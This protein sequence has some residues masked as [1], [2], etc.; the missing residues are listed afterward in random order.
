LVPVPIA[1]PVSRPSRA[2]CLYEARARLAAALFDQ[3]HHLLEQWYQLVLVHDAWLKDRACAWEALEEAVH[4]CQERDQQLLALE[5]GLLAGQDELR[6]RQTALAQV[7]CA[8]EGWHAR[9]TVRESAW[10]TDRSALIAE[11]DER[12][13]S[14]AAQAARIDELGRHRLERRAQEIEALRQARV[15]C[16]EMRRDYAGLWKE[17]QDRRATL[18]Q[19]QRE[20]ASRALALETLRQELVNRTTDPAAATRRMERLQRQHAARLRA[21][22]KNLQEDQ[23]RVSAEVER[24][25]AWSQQLR[26]SEETL[27]GRQQEWTYQ[28]IALEDQ[29]AATTQAELQQQLEIKR[30]RTVHEA[31]G[32]HIAQ[33]EEEIERV[34]RLLMDEGNAPQ[35]DAPAAKEAA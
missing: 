32:R 25:Q 2:I 12:E 29:R 18:A 4:R 8:L 34:A 20:L 27:I 22:E 30:L 6:Q 16:E 11:M 13:V 10:Q 1:L 17:C 19:Q 9:L 15:Q 31:Q 28:E 21:E 3:R 35:L 23:K 7:R 33:L 14:T 5:H 24:L 26:T